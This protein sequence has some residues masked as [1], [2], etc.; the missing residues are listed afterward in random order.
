MNNKLF[1]FFVFV[2]LLN[3]QIFP[4]KSF[5]VGVYIQ[6]ISQANLQKAKD[7][8]F[9][10]FQAPGDNSVLSYCKSNN[11]KLLSWNFENNG[12]TNVAPGWLSSGYYSIWYG[13]DALIESAPKDVG[14]R[15]SNNTSIVNYQNR[16]CIKVNQSDPQV[17]SG[18]YY[19]QDIKPKEFLYSNFNKYSTTLSLAWNDYE[20]V[21]DNTVICEVGARMKLRKIN[22]GP[23][24]TTEI[25]KVPLNTIGDKKLVTAGELRGGIFLEITFDYT[26][27]NKIPQLVQITPLRG[28]SLSSKKVTYNVEYVYDDKVTWRYI[29]DGKMPSCE[30]ENLGIE[31][32]MDFKGYGELYFDYVTARD[33]RM[34]IE[35]DE[36]DMISY[37]NGINSNY[38][39]TI[40]H[41]YSLDE[42]HAI[43]NFF[44]YNIINTALKNSNNQ[45]LITAFYPEWDGSA[46]LGKT[47][48]RFNKYANPDKIMIDHYPYW[49]T[50]TNNFGLNEL[51]NRIEEV[52]LTGKDFWYCSQGFGEW[53]APAGTP[54]WTTEGAE[55]RHPSSTELKAS[56]MLALS[57]G[58]KSIF[59][60]P[61]NYYEKIDTTNPIEDKSYKYTGLLDEF[62]NATP[63]SNLFQ[64]D[65]VPRL[66]GKLGNT[67][68]DLNYSSNQNISV[69]EE[70]NLTD[71]S[72]ILFDEEGEYITLN[73]YDIS[74]N[75]RRNLN[76]TL[77][78]NKY[79]DKEKYFSVV[80]LEC[81]EN[82]PME[83]EIMSFI[84]YVSTSWQP[85]NNYNTFTFRDIEDN[86]YVSS[87]YKTT[88]GTDITFELPMGEGKFF[89][90]APAVIA[91]GESNHYEYTF[92]GDTLK[93]NLKIN[94]SSKLYVNYPYVVNANILLSSETSHI[95][96]DSTAQLIV[97]QNGSIT[98]YG[99]K[100]IK[101]E[102]T[103]NHP[104]LFW[105]AKTGVVNYEVWRG[106]EKIATVTGTSYVDVNIVLDDDPD[107]YNKKV[108]YYIK[109]NYQG[110][111]YNTNTIEYYYY[112]I[113]LD[114]KGNTESKKLE[115]LLSQNY[116]NPFN[117]TTTINFSILK[118]DYTTIKIYDILGNEIAVLVDKYMNKGEYTIDLDVNKYNLSSGVYFYSLS[119]G[120]FYKT[121][122]MIINK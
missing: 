51:N 89:I 118:D 81:N 90:L 70:V 85:V 98:P 105:G 2:L 122:K 30:L 76:F 16:S 61:L 92:P 84:P 45:P 82:D 59:V 7:I 10:Y 56:I 26:Y 96:V 73:G 102:T 93:Y 8:G 110:T 54:Y 78:K 41:W 32:F 99:F 72:Y 62:G 80:N 27:E 86:N 33:N 40:A 112:R 64:D 115:Y 28:D 67:L 11:I 53:I 20:G 5:P 69:I 119:S 23:P 19:K 39:N 49:W 17:I 24:I 107:N 116:P 71:Y 15:R 113:L 3:T 88:I 38:K 95:I 22:W 97:T 18:P 121:N 68:L 111:T 35:Y 9:N 37:V 43:D 55:W 60:W 13:K 91:G 50:S 66:K 94:S 104:Y 65:I 74:G 83:D 29:N 63:L 44:T 117:P 1:H 12:G 106:T 52:T 100:L 48:E 114:K 77:L 34:W 75:N 25:I 6:D 101:A 103:S 87:F 31:Y 57:K 36:A 46:N 14:L 4:Q 108:S 58:A 120:S 21:P 79:T 47:I 42:P 109:C